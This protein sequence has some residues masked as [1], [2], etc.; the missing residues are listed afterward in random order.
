[1]PT[2]KPKLTDIEPDIQ[3]LATTKCTSISGR[4]EVRYS[5]GVLGDVIHV[6]LVGSSGGAQINNS[7]I[8]YVD[9]QKLLENYSGGGSFNS[10][11]FDPIFSNVSSNNCGFT[12]A[13]ALKEKLVLP[14]EGKRRKFVH[15]S[16]AAFLA[17]VDKLTAAKATKPA[18]KRK[19][20]AAAK[21]RVSL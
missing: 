19:T 17:K 2:R 13:V 14:Q 6:K 4:S 5:I 12:L 8:P 7:W 18:T 10:S 9:I 3:L 21:S 1:M 16:P 11:V 15:N 20:K